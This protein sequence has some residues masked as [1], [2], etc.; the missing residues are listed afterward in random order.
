MH[1]GAHKTGTSL[2]Q[3][4]FR[5][6]PDVT[7]ALRIAQISRTDGDLLVDWGQLLHE[8]PHDL[9]GR[10]EKEAAAD[11]SVILFS[12][13]NTLG[14]PFVLDRPGLYPDASRHATAL[15]E[16]CDGFDPLVVF[17][18]RPMAD[19]LESYYIQTVQEGAWHSFEAWFETVCGPTTWTRV[20]EDLRE[21][22]G[23]DRVVV[24]DFTE[25]AAGQDQF[26]QQFMSRT[27]IP[28]PQ[29]VHY[30]PVRNP[31]FNARGLQIARDINHHLD[32]ED[33]RM[34]MRKFLQKHFS[35]RRDGRAQPMP[36]ELRRSIEEQ[37]AAEYAMLAKLA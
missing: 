26:L 18:I 19:F 6:N 23:S 7:E 22:F 14:R 37:T 8:R 35:N 13:E 15:A 20:V 27:G 30:K 10:L 31:S 25:I 17:Y 29:T 28:Q 33:E 16:I 3:K 21:A 2:V 5:D 4:Y 12:H 36:V 11:P 1:V 9:R 34:I 32:D 24:G